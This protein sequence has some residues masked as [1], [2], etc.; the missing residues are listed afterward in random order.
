MVY[1]YFSIARRQSGGSTIED[2]GK[3]QPYWPSLLFRLIFLILI[4]LM[5]RHCSQKTTHKRVKIHFC[6]LKISLFNAGIHHLTSFHCLIHM[7][8]MLM[9]RFSDSLKHYMYLKN[10]FLDQSSKKQLL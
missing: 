5:Q 3:I 1:R 2:M 10:L 4:I 6:L 9:R 7:E 8:E